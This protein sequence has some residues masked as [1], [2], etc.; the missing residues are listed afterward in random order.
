MAKIRVRLNPILKVRD[1]NVGVG[2]TIGGKLQRG[3]DGKFASAKPPN[4]FDTLSKPQKESMIGAIIRR[5]D[6]TE[7]EEQRKLMALLERVRAIMAGDLEITETDRT[8]LETAAVFESRN[9]ENIEEGAD[10]HDDLE[11]M[12][13][14]DNR[15]TT[16]SKKRKV[17]I[18]GKRRMKSSI[19]SSINEAPSDE[20]GDAV[21]ECFFFVTKSDDDSNTCRWVGVSSTS[22]YPDRDFEGIT[23]KAH[24]DDIR[25]QDELGLHGVK[26]L[27]FWHKR[28]IPI[29]T[30][31]FAMMIGPYRVESGTINKQ[32]AEQLANQRGQWQMSFGFLPL[33]QKDQGWFNSIHSTESTLVARGCAANFLTTHTIS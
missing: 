22:F 3:D 9:T 14:L 12:E 6:A 15:D 11:E 32:I 26:P 4:P 24:E 10:D 2:E 5:I 7:G 33:S 30:V 1:F 16:T 18:T 20:G 13:V 8:T 23:I 21:D 31:D 19:E 25:R 29:G 28:D 17:R 27:L